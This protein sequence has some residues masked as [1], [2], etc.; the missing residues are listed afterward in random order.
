MDWVGGTRPFAMHPDYASL[1]LPAPVAE[2]LG[3]GYT[4]HGPLALCQQNT[5]LSTKSAQQTSS[6]CCP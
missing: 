5:A 2:V 6:G 4:V 3:H 1:I